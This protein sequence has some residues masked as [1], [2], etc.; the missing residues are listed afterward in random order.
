MHIAR[1]LMELLI[2]VVESLLISNEKVC[3]ISGVEL[4]S[5]RRYSSNEL[6]KLDLV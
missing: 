1:Y 5:S 2:S 3:I 6:S 4:M